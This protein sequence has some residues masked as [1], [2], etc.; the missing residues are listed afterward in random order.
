MST[1]TIHAYTAAISID[2]AADYLLIDPNSTGT[3]NKINRN[4]LLGITSTPIGAADSQTL[5]NKTL[6]NSNAITVKDGSFT[7]QNTSDTTKRAVFSASGITTG[8]T[9]TLTLPNRT[10]TLVTLAGAESLTNKTLTSP[11]ITG[12]TIDNSTITVDSISGHTS[13]GIVTVGGVQMSSGV[14]NTANS[15]TA[16]SIAASAVQP[17]ALQSGTGTGWAWQSYSPVWTAAGTA[18]ALG[19]GTLSGNYVQVGKTI[20]YRIFWKAGSTTTFGTQAWRFSLPVSANSAI[21][22]PVG[23]VGGHS[24]G[25]WY[26]EN[27][28]TTGY[29]GTSY[30]VSATTI[31]FLVADATT[32]GLAQLVTSAVPAAWA[33][34][35]YMGIT[36]S[37]EAA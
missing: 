34:T 37:Y 24:T 3:Y 35:W 22:P 27:P 19:N 29:M 12:G 13:A 10:D 21:L 18:P 36:G 5:S 4:V 25:T 8:T 33:N 1:K 31:A 2:G 7:I 32:S 30:I 11:T 6:D 15:V 23:G 28:S 20:H 9:R 16:A 17:Q 14:V 26:A